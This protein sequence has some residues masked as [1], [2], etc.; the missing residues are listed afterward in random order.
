MDYERE[1]ELYQT[2]SDIVSYLYAITEKVEE[3]AEVLKP[4]TEGE[5]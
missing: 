3:L 2:I 1:A 4:E 5:G